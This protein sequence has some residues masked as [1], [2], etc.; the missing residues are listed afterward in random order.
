MIDQMIG[1]FKSA[2][3]FPG[4]G[5]SSILIAI[6]LGLAFGAIWLA[7][8]RPPFVARPFLWVVLASSAIITW[9]AIAFVQIPLQQWAGLALAHFFDA[10]TLTK[11][12]L[13]AGIPQI[14]LSGLVQEAAKLVPVIVY[15][16]RSHGILLRSS[17]LLSGRCPEQD[18]VSSRLSGFT[19][20]SS[21][22]VGR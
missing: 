16:W 17:V 6:G 2:F 12:L 7:L 20:P 18:L 4:L 5:W 8:Y 9:T 3:V 11:W 10:A 21:P 15:W 14:F 13:L 19:T 22:A 1:F